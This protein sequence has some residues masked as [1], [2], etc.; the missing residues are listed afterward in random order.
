[1]K[2]ALLLVLPLL[3]LP[4]AAGAGR[5]GHPLALVTA[6]TQNRLLVVDTVTGRVLRRLAVPADPQNVEAYAGQAAVVSTRAGAVTLLDP[7]TLKVQRV[8]RG[9]ASPHIAAFAPGGDY[10]YVTDDARGQLAVIVGRTVRRLFVGHGAHHLAFSPDQQ[11]LLIALGERARA[12]AVVDTRNPFR[13][14]LEGDFSA[15]GLAHDLAFTPDGRFIWV[16]YDDR[17]YL[18]V[19]ATRS[20]QPVATLYAGPPPA[21]VRFDDAYAVSPWGR[22]AYVTSGNAAT[23]RVFDWRR[24]RLVRLVHTSPGSFNLAID[25][26]LVASSS[27]SDG[28]LTVVRG[29]RR[30]LSERVASSARDVA[31]VP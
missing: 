26:G 10:L 21:H 17:P 7:R 15:R 27:L 11:R 1:M 24:R 6:E 18:R 8:I 4:G 19:F 29:G 5:P 20:L 3:L 12:I 16:T 31:L 28:V 30:T 23:L 2:R 13:P 9:F 14:R 22:F 25:H